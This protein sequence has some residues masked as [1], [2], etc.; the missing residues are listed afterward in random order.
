MGGI[1][2]FMNKKQSAPQRTPFGTSTPFDHR[3]GFFGVVTEVH[4]ET[5]TVHVFTDTGI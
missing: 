2:I 3:N 5:N 4:P 1:N